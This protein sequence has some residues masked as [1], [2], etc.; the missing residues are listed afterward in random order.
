MQF[1]TEQ[2]P[3]ICVLMLPYFKEGQQML[4]HG[5]IF[6]SIIKNMSTVTNKVYSTFKILSLPTL[7]LSSMSIQT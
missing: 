3:N 5:I 4:K 7:Y 2:Q 6:K 1:N